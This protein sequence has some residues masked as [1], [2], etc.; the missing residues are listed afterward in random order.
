[1]LLRSHSPTPTQWRKPTTKSRG[2]LHDDFSEGWKEIELHLVAILVGPTPTPLTA[3]LSIIH[4]TETTGNVTPSHFCRS[5]PSSQS[6][7]E[8][9]RN[10]CALLPDLIFE[11]RRIISKKEIRTARRRGAE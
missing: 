1:M 10:E 2:N 6:N 4:L 5:P 8:K 11:L 7:D 9:M 3:P